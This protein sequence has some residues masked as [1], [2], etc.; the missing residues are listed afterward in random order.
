MLAV[1]Q[2]VEVRVRLCLFLRSRFGRGRERVESVE[3][4]GL[5]LCFVLNETRVALCGC[6]L[7]HEEFL[8]AIDS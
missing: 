5:V 1:E 7:T 8:D 4:L 3:H 6:I 2:L